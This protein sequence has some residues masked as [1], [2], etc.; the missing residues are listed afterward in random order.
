MELIFQIT[1]SSNLE[2]IFWYRNYNFK[3][4]KGNIRKNI[5]KL[6]SM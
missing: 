1:K 4:N 6:R 2:Q 3:E 5:K